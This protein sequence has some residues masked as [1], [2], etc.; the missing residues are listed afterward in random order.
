M[1]RVRDGHRPRLSPDLVCTQVPTATADRCSQSSSASLRASAR[2]RSGRSTG[3]RGRWCSRAQATVSGSGA[4]ERELVA[5]DVGVQQVQPDLAGDAG[6]RAPH[7][8]HVAAGDGGRQRRDDPAVG[9]AGRRRSCRRRAAGRRRAPAG[10]P[11]R[12][13]RARPGGRRRR[14]W[15][16]S[17]R[18]MRRH[19]SRSPGSSCS[20]THASAST[21]GPPGRSDPKNRRTRCA[22][23]AIRRA[24]PRRRARDRGSTPPSAEHEDH[25]S[26]I[27]RRPSTPQL[28]PRRP[29]PPR[30]RP[31]DDRR[32][33]ERRD[34]EQ[35]EQRRAAG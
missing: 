34:R 1:A 27:T 8:G 12:R 23:R 15:R 21:P 35:V 11:R 22:A 31:L 6:L 32:A 33:V 16:R 9:A 26:T 30:Q 17:G 5:A 19:S 3:P 10:S 4:G 18:D 28:G 13:G 7:V 24:T 20:A 2:W 29:P 14:A 25:D